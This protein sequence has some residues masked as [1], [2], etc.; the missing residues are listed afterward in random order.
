[1]N[2]YE[3]GSSKMNNKKYHTVGTFLKPNRQVV[4]RGQ[5][6]AHNTQIHDL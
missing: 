5:I 4:E 2:W 3:P 1:M 6:D